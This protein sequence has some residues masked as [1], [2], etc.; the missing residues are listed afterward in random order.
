MQLK[1]ALPALTSSKF[2][3]MI[4]LTTV[5]YF[6]HSAIA[7]HI[8]ACCGLQYSFTRNIVF[9]VTDGVM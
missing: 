9:Q 1:I 8:N 2:E 7:M 4:T 6:A 3:L 5:S